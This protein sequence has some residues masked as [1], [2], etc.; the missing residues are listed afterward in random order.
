MIKQVLPFMVG[1]FLCSS[2]MAQVPKQINYQ[3]IAR[4]T[5]GTALSNQTINLRLTIREAN[6]TGAVI[7]QETRS[8][9]TN[10]FG[11]FSTAIGGE[12]A[13]SVSGSL[14]GINWSTGTAKFL[15]VEMDPKGGNQF[16]A[17]GTSPLT[18][19]PFAF[20]AES[21]NPV[22]AAGGDLNGSFP[23]PTIKDGAVSGS[24]IATGSI[25]T[26]KVAD[27]AITAAK[28][29]PG[30]IPSSLP[31]SGTA[32]GD[33]TGTYPNPTIANN[34]VGTSKIV[35]G[36]I[37][38]TK[39]ADN[40]VSTNKIDANAITNAKLANNAVAT[41]NVQ[42]GAITAAKIAPG[43]IPSSVPVSGTAGGDLTGTYPNPTISN[44]A[45]NTNKIAA[46]AVTNAKLAN[47]AVATSNVQDGAITAAKLAP[48]VIPSSLPV[49]GTAGGDLTGT[50]PN[51]T[52]ANN[53]VGAAKIADG[54]VGNTKLADGSV[55]TAKITDAAVNSN[56]LA[57]NAVSS[58]KIAANA[59]TNAKLA[60]NS[61]ATTN[62]QD[63]A[64]TAAKLAPG[65]IPSSLPVSG[66]AGGDLT[67]TYPN[68]TIANN[69]V[70]ATKI[71]DGAVG[72]TK[73]A[74]NAVATTNVQDGAI[75]AAKLA[76]GVIPSSLPVSGTAGGDLTGTYPN[77]TIANN[78]VS[79]TKIAD[80]AVG[81][82]KLADGA[83]SNT[84]LADNA[85]SSN[86][87]AASA[88]TNAK[89]AT[90]SIA[91]A[92]V[93]DGAITA[94]K[95]APGV[96]PSSLPVSGTAGGDLTGTYPNPTIANNAIGATK[97]ADGAVGAAKIADGAVGNAKLSTN[98]VATTNVQDG[99]I[100]AAKIAPGVIPTSLPVSGTA[101]GDLT[102]TY[103]NP[104]IANNAVG[105]TKIADGAVGTTKLADNAV[106]SNKIAAS[107]VTNAK[108]ATNS[109]ATANVQDGA[110]TAA[111]IAPGVIPTSLPVSGTAGGDLTGTYPN[112]TIA[113]NAV[114]ATKIADGAVSSA[115]IADG[116]V[117]NTKLADGA[118]STAKILDAAVNS[119][120][121]ADNAVSSNKIAASAV[122]NAKLATNSVATANVQ[123][124]AITAAKIA[125]GVIPTSLPVSGTAGGD[126]SGT[127]PNPTV[128]RI[129]GVAVSTTAP[130]VGQVLKYNGTQWAPGTDNAG[131]GGLTFP[132]TNTTNVAGEMFGLTNSGNGTAIAGSNNS[133]GP[134]AIGIAGSITNAA[135][136][137]LATGLFGEVSS[138]TTNNGF[139]IFGRHRGGGTAIYGESVG[140]VGVFGQSTS[141]YGVVARSNSEPAIFATS[142]GNNAAR[143]ENTEMS[144][145]GEV[146]N[147][148]NMYGDGISVITEQGAG[149]K[150]LHLNST[151]PS[152]EV[153]NLTNGVGVY[154]ATSSDFAA[155][156]DARNTET[157]AAILGYAPQGIG[158]QT[159]TNMEGF[160][161]GIGIK[162][163]IGQAGSASHA[164]F[165]TNG[166][167]VARIDENGRGFFNGGTTNSGADVAELFAVVGNR[168]AYE[169]GDVLEI[170]TTDDRKMVK[171]SGAYSTL[172]A[173]V[174]ATKPGL[175]LTEENATE[176]DL[177]FGVPMG[178]IGVLPTKVC[179]EGGAI[180]R[181]D[182]IVTSSIPGVAM[183][184]DPEKV[185]VGQVLGKALQDYSGS[186]IG[187]INVLVSV[188]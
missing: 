77:P 50:Y 88:V 78:A 53:A 125:P 178:V 51:P 171:S 97:I 12:G 39:L 26:D 4:N 130:T 175:L 123:D 11:L 70:S 111:K 17:M 103:P 75:T 134:A 140:G 7:Y 135:P 31:V 14:N 90:N 32:G 30:V 161:G 13:S 57:D 10:Q 59:V 28:L 109:I 46:N 173:G 183:K 166:A 24:K 23:N 15:Q 64:I 91:T 100:T 48:G 71:A 38:T 35:D 67:G 19:V 37:S 102:G 2:L 22:G 85:V 21:A 72:N 150:I 141:T 27:G 73:L 172:V 165:E 104:T 93:Q 108:M 96:I 5:Y 163:V 94:A 160:T 127:Y 89:M 153:Q 20:R 68:P 99:A 187:K 116:A 98:A 152:I 159:E 120:K 184:A 34:A 154:S 8:V 185:K 74:S 117:G 105:A 44:N 121:L 18:S 55:S 169:P 56:K 115:K 179:M 174:Y 65:V 1:L 52:I 25:S 148:Y 147:V 138:A 180:K 162:S 66:T 58:N 136:S 142:Q 118:V 128:G 110:I 182:L 176:G 42:D 9:T 156:I 106:N 33:L 76:P 168:N 81:A 101:G 126:L 82:A 112:P 60:S 114:G 36:A 79:A 188:K 45:I 107:A 61:V 146:L 83:V 186:G 170:S 124:G 80:G 139:A 63:G 155:A 43:V 157:F 16:M 62:V 149:L 144:N 29:A 49:S 129:N 84:K 137:F 119:N 95:L 92:N 113:N 164:I 3:G 6:A 133:A 69:A 145:M 54:A 47:N 167:N 87:I 131:G 86:K 158:I 151:A 41:A 177:S 132:F 181:G 122:T 143:F 40:A